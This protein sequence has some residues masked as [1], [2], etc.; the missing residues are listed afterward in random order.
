MSKTELAP[1]RQRR[2]YP[3]ALKAQIVAQC[4]QPGMSVAGV[5]LSH[6]INANVVRKWIR[7]AEQL[8]VL[9]PTFVPIMPPGLPGAGRY[10][11]IR[12]SRGPVQATVQWP[13][14]EAGACVSW[15]REWLR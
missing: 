13:V 10:I 7:Q 9:P 12:L 3:K 15:L 2:S 5:A 6:G 14:S 8:P 4:R 1:T 11:E